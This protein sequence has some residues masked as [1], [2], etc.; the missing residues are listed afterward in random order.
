[1][2]V[3]NYADAV[4]L[5]GQDADAVHLDWHRVYPLPH[6]FLEP[7][8]GQVTTP[9]TPADYIDG[10]IRLRA[11]IR[12]ET[13]PT[14]IANVA[15]QRVSSAS[16]ITWDWYTDNLMRLRF[17][18]STTGTGLIISSTPLPDGALVPGTVDQWIGTRFERT[19]TEDIVKGDMSL[20][21]G[22]T[23]TEITNV[24]RTA[25]GPLFNS[26]AA[27]VV[28]ALASGGQKFPG[29]IY[30]CEMAAINQRAFLFPGVVGNYMSS[31]DGNTRRLTGD[32]EWVARIVPTTWGPTVAGTIVA[33]YTNVYSS[34]GFMVRPGRVLGFLY[35][36]PGGT[37]VS[38]N[39]SAAVPFADGVGG[40]V[41]A[42]RRR[43]DGVVQFFTAPDGPA[44]P[45]TWTKLGTDQNTVAGV[46]NDTPNVP[47]YIGARWNDFRDPFA[48]RVR[49]V[50]LRDA[51]GGPPVLDVGERD[52]QYVPPGATSFLSADVGPRYVSFPGTVGNYLSLP[53]SAPLRLTGSFEVVVRAMLNWQSATETNTL[54][55]KLATTGIGGR[56]WRLYMDPAFPGRPRLSVSPDG[57]TSQ[58]AT[59]TTAIG[60]ANGV[61]CWLKATYDAPTGTIRFW[62][63][64]D[65]DA[66]PV[67]A[68][69]IQRG[70]DRTGYPTNM[71]AGTAR[72]TI[73]RHDVDDTGPL[74]GTIRRVILRNG[75]GGTTVLDVDPTANL[76]LVDPAATSF[77]ATAGGTVTVARAGTPPA[78]LRLETGRTP[79]TV[80]QVPPA[81]IVNGQPDTI[82]WRFDASEWPPKAA[83][84]VGADARTWTTT[85][86]ATPAHPTSQPDAE[87]V[88]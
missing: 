63:C 46:L 10:S 39:S 79:V 2:T 28:G 71:F 87:L 5:G 1:M 51:I 13:A 27:I 40:W 66:E 30:W 84:V 56:S 85:N 45:T 9:D 17:R 69:W 43:S 23:W 14:V 76:F 41:K 74:L 4:R 18:V 88:T 83:S 15:W 31:P 70:G 82:L 47:V 12:L 34:W 48:G 33:K 32:A 29:R 24:P 37:G 80:V 19:P 62:E 49:R 53:D 60:F 78:V 68:A 42:T 11:R 77:P 64:A 26:T 8:V 58:T 81:Q 50:I 65:Q 7:P 52:A 86:V 61:R 16:N 67:G 20:D 36:P 22:V 59:A 55:A 75:I 57:S 35:V 38:I 44:E 6:A 21:G 3:L 54:A 73:G 25:V 72:V